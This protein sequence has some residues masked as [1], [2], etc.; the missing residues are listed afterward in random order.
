MPGIVLFQRW[1][2]RGTSRIILALCLLGLPGLAAAQPPRST[3]PPNQPTGPM[4]VNGKTL[5][6]WKLLLTHDD[7]SKRT[8][9]I[10][11]V[12]Q[13][14]EASSEVVPLLLSRTK[15]RD[16]SP[17]LRAVTALRYVAVNDK[18]VHKV[19]ME[20][21]RLLDPRNER[22]TAVRYEAAWTLERF[23]LDAEPALPALIQ[24]TRDP[25]AFEVRLRCVQ[26][27]WRV[28]SRS[29]GGPDDQAVLALV[30]RLGANE[31][32]HFVKLEAVVGL[33]GI[34]KPASTAAQ[35]QVN[36]ALERATRS[37]NKVYAIWAYAGL[38]SMNEKVADTS[39]LAI[40]KFLKNS[41]LEV[42]AQAAQ[43][44]GALRGR[45]KSRIPNLIAMLDD[46]EAIAV[47][48]ACMAL[49]QIG[50]HDNR[51][52]D[53]LIHLL[54]HKDPN[55]VASACMALVELGQ[56]NSRVKEAIE[57]QLERKDKDS[58]QLRLFIRAALEHLEKP[59]K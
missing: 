40:S 10:F 22:E 23:Y 58:D 39:L 15:D 4:Q 17:R 55:R 41:D 9:A 53:A 45:A 19:V 26:M 21:A 30:E 27:L 16:A 48:G 44:L 36:A 49:A 54:D 20:M 46:K 47:H 34:G 29:K 33:A 52:L 6:E 3:N 50:E 56:G 14:G 5:A 59:K 7:P 42:R 2:V 8:Q 37:T 11:A 35:L 31:T 1:F 57:K 43:A 28:A 38:V 24:G 51:V 12:V 13:F 32:T 18:D 25:G